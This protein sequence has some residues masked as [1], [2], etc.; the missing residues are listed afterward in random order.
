[1]LSHKTHETVRPEFSGS[2]LY[3][4][5]SQSQAEQKDQDNEMRIPKHDDYFGQPDDNEEPYLPSFFRAHLNNI[6]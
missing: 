2:W 5:H 6:I 1:M 3:A 4:N